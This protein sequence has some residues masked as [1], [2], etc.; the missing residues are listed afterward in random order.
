MRWIGGLGEFSAGYAWLS[1]KSIHFA[2][3]RTLCL[4]MCWG[5]KRHPD[6]ATA[7]CVLGYWVDV[8]VVFCAKRVLH[9]SDR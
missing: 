7:N 8:T 2:G 6:S 3:I 9:G 4:E 5:T 1:R